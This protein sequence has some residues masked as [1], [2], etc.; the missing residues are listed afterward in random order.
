MLRNLVT[1]LFEHEQIR[2][3][4]PKAKDTARLAD[5]IITLGK[6]GTESAYQRAQ[7]FVLKPNVLP[8]LFETFAQRYANRPGGYT[9]IH[10]IDNRTGDNAPMALLEL[11][12][13]PRD[14]KLEMTARAVGRDLLTEKLRWNSPRGVLNSGVD[15]L[16]SISREVKLGTHDKGELRPATRRNLQKVIRYR[17]NPSLRDVGKKASAWIDTLFAMPLQQRRVQMAADASADAKNKAKPTNFVDK[18]PK[19]GSRAGAAAPGD[20]R[21]AVRLAQGALARPRRPTR[22]VSAVPTPKP[23]D[24]KNLQT[25]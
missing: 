11:V 17:G 3:T 18:F 10:R 15:A 13:N 21:S 6:K 19:T 2:T 14:F 25:R 23:Y 22:Y 24:A 16:E 12:D 7:A 9:R 5:K 4:L 1:S 8:K 20:M